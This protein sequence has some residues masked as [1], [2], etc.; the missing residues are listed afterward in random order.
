M[1]FRYKETKNHEGLCENAGESLSFHC[2]NSQSLPYSPETCNIKLVNG[3][4][5][6]NDVDYGNPD[7]VVYIQNGYG[8]PSR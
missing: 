5:L 4:F 7:N 6:W 2:A 8:F 3:E 1:S